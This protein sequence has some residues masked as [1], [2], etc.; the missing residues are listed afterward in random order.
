MEIIFTHLP[1]IF[2]MQN[3]D[4]TVEQLFHGHINKTFCVKKNGIPVYI[5]QKVNP[6]V[7]RNIDQLMDNYQKVTSVLSDYQWPE[8]IQLRIPEIIHTLNGNLYY[9]DDKNKNWR[10]ITY[11]EGINTDGIP[12]NT[13]ISY[14]GGLAFGAFL[15]G[16]SSIDTKS[17]NTI[18]PD[19][20]S[21]ENR[22]RDF[23]SSVK[24]NAAGRV[25]LISE[26][27][28]FVLKRH[29]FMMQIP[30]RISSGE[31]PWRAA[32]NDSKLTNVIFSENEKAVGIIDLD[33]V[34]AG[35]A[36][37]DFG[38]AIRS[39]AN[40]AAEDEPDLSKVSFEIELFEAFSR[41][42][43]ESTHLLLTKAEINLLSESALFMTYII[44]VRFLTDYL[45]GDTYFHIDYENHNLV[46]ARVQFRLLSLMESEIDNMHRIIDRIKQNLP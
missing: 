33:T 1:A 10:L 21:L 32:H 46:R 40:S 25:S 5:L 29:E 35:S 3:G 41:G 27:I 18:L 42:F 4:Y 7:F 43:L 9:T 39:S 37:F 28:E 30:N 12:R 36:L 17:L 34:M 26:E 38:D 44:G 20:H 13:N 14:Q 11:I 6:D 8:E 45:K 31:I 24:S 16:I 19:F 22:Y 15:R 2:Q 23:L